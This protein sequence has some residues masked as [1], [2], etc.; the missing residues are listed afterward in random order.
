MLNAGQ[1]AST[2]LRA[3]QRESPAAWPVGLRQ[4]ACGL[5][6]VATFALLWALSLSGIREAGLDAQAKHENLRAEFSAKLLLAAALVTTQSQQARSAQRLLLLEKQLPGPHEMTLLLADISRLGR[7]R[8]LRFEL[9][10]PAEPGRQLPYA[11]QHIAVRVAGRYQDLLG[12]AADVAS[13]HWLVS[14]HSFSVLPS[15]EGVL[16][17]DASVRTLRPLAVTPNVSNPSKSVS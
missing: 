15:K 4:L 16:L 12:F 1:M 13:L 17:M 6:F 5:V 7:A 14:I 8:K 2:Y 10:R 9:L 3:V 11:Q